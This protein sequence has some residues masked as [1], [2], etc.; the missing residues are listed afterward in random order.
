MRKRELLISLC[1][2]AA[3]DDYG[4]P[5]AYCTYYSPRTRAEYRGQNPRHMLLLQ[6]PPLPEGEAASRGNG[7]GY[8]R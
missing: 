1:K 2:K 8:A 6:P 7:V 3:L 4:M 5:R